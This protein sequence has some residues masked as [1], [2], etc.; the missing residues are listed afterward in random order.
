MEETSQ[1][2]VYTDIEFRESFGGIRTDGF[3][4]FEDEVRI[5]QG[6]TVRVIFERP[7]YGRPRDGVSG[8]P[9]RTV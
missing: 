3:W 4:R 8:L 9:T 1:S 2:A 7:A 6:R 5:L